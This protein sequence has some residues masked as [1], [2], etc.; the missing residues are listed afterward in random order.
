VIKLS[1]I[2]EIKNKLSFSEAVTQTAPLAI[3]FRNLNRV[4]F[5]VAGNLGCF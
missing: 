4:H 5:L 3:S 2:Y 1:K